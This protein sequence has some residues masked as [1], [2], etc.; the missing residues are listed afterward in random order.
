MSYYKT[1]AKWLGVANPFQCFGAPGTSE[2][3]PLCLDWDDR[4]DLIPEHGTTTIRAL[5]DCAIVRTIL[6]EAGVPVLYA[7]GHGVHAVFPNT[8]RQIDFRVVLDL[9]AMREMGC[10]TYALGSSFRIP[11]E[12]GGTVCTGYASICYV[13]G[14]TIR[15]GRKPGRGRDITRLTPRGESNSD[16]IRAHDAMVRRY[17]H[18]GVNA[19]QETTPL[20]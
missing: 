7:T 18:R 6:P 3:V 13:D 11:A 15:V 20:F 1:S 2:R 9:L 14:P 10:C 8:V 4:P 5:H 16:M 12:C 19:P 17:N